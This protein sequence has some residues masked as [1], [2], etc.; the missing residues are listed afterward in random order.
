MNLRN[1][2]INRSIDRHFPL[3][4]IHSLHT[5]SVGRSVHG[6]VSGP[7]EVGGLEHLHLLVQHFG[8]FRN[9]E[10]L[11]QRG[12]PSS[13]SSSSSLQPSDRPTPSR[14]GSATHPLRPLPPSFPPSPPADSAAER[15]T[16]PSSR[17]ERRSALLSLA[18]WSESQSGRDCPSERERERG[19][20]ARFPPAAPLAP[21]SLSGLGQFIRGRS[22]RRLKAAADPP[23][24]FLQRRREDQDS[25]GNY[26][27]ATGGGGGAGGDTSVPYI[28]WIT[29][30][31]VFLLSFVLSPLLGF[32]T[33]MLRA[34]ESARC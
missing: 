14:I 28:H 1:V 26:L 20:I 10:G 21:S 15:S 24:L 7:P 5:A 32:A 4:C 12:A 34:C 25:L 13:L 19:C 22:G 16:R 2:S 31:S 17:E 29:R 11:S 23:D 33:R 3:R 6:S 9:L 30:S 8:S 18:R 27:S